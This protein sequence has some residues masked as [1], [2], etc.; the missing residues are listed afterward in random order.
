MEEVGTWSTRYGKFTPQCLL[1][2]LALGGTLFQF[3]KNLLNS[4][5]NS[6]SSSNN[7]SNNYNNK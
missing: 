1:N 7:N 2:H 4:N 6:N 3:Q 5:S